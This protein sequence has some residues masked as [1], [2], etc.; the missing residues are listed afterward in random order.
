MDSLIVPL[1][2]LAF[3]DVFLVAVG[4]KKN[5]RAFEIG[6]SIGFAFCIIMI[7]AIIMLPLL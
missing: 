5:I 6:G 2:I 7:F 3:V 4:K 1:A